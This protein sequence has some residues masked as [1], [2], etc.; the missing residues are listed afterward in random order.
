M[1]NNEDINTANTAAQQERKPTDVNAETIEAIKDE[2]YVGARDRAGQ[3]LKEAGH[4]VVVTPEENKRILRKIDLA[5]LPI[6]LFVYCLQSLD[7]TSLAYASV[8]GLIEHA[9]LVGDQYS[10]LGAIVYVA[11]LVW[12][13]VVAYFLVKF[14]IGKFCAIMVFCCKLTLYKTCLQKLKYTS[15]GAPYSAA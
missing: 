4:S 7:K 1:A 11:Q 10:W 3:M 15:Q 14:P 13:P 9:D 5:I 6:L 2:Q 12:Q 8:F